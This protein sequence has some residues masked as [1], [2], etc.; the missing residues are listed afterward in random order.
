[1]SESVVGVAALSALSQMVLSEERYV[2]EEG[3]GT[4][5]IKPA[6]KFINIRPKS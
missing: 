6:V 1:M 4:P 2:I 5:H 3:G